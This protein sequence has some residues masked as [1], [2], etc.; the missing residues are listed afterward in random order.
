MSFTAD[1]KYLGSLLI[2]NLRL[3]LG[4]ICDLGDTKTAAIEGD[5]CFILTTGQRRLFLAGERQATAGQAQAVVLGW[6]CGR[7]F[8]SNLLSCSWCR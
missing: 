3:W 4:D 8:L 1:C 2:E 5:R 7:L 6:C